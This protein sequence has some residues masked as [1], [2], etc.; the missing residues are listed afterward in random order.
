[1]YSYDRRVSSAQD[2]VLADIES[3]KLK[4]VQ[5]N[6]REGRTVEALIQKGV[7]GYK[8]R[9]VEKATKTPYGRKLPGFTLYTG[10]YLKK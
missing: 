1:M 3:G 6:T 8:H 7:V 2:K 10:L 4:T 5:S 9:Q